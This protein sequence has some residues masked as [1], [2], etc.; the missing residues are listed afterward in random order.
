M[1]MHQV[2]TGEFREGLSDLLN[3]VRF[4]HDIVRITKHGKT[5]GIVI[6]EEEYEKY[7]QI[8]EQME[9]AEDLQAAEK[10]IKE[11]EGEET[12][13]WEQV[14]KDLDVNL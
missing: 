10:A 13:S 1:S 8:K 9:D 12:I 3:A 2:S 5:M 14:K 4:A 6:S 11:S 7:L